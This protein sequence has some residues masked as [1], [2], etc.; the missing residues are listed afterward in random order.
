MASGKWR[1]VLKMLKVP[2]RATARVATRYLKGPG[3]SLQGE[4][5]AI[6]FESRQDK[7]GFMLCAGPLF[8]VGKT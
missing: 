1:T 4:T 8:A 7:N 6:L 3:S 2:V 5:K